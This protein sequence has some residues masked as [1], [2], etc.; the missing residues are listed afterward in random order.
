MTQTVRSL[1]FTARTGMWTALG[2]VLIAVNLRPAIVAVAPIVGELRADTGLSSATVGLLTAIPLLCFGLLSPIMPHIARRLGMEKTVFLSM[3]LLCAGFG[4]RGMPTTASLFLGTILIGIAITAGNVLLPGLIKQD[5]KDRPGLMMGLYSVGLFTGAALAGG[6]TVP[7]A[8]SAGW[9]WRGALAIWM[10]LAIAGTLAWLPQLLRQRAHR[11]TTTIKTARVWRSRLAWAVTGYMGLQSLH[12]YT[13]SAWMPEILISRGHDPTLAG[14]FL[15]LASI[16]AMFTSLLV[17]I[18]AGRRDNQ[19][20]TG[21]IITLLAGVG[22]GGLLY[23]P[24]L[25]V[26]AVILLGLAQGG[27]I[28]LALLLLL[29]RTNSPADAAALSGMSQS[30]GYLLAAAG[31]VA[32]GALHDWSEGWPVPLLVL[33]A[34]LIPQGYCAYTAGASKTV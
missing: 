33:I 23:A 26:L 1:R 4:I 5:F 18:F 28:G 22:L 9:D 10:L 12:Y 27:A 20:W 25:T 16:A 7:L 15:A 8:R 17:P 2:V 21:V 19:R 30:A 24:Q 6:I 29:L 11:S 3:L 13:V 14:S 34:L 31:P 32:I